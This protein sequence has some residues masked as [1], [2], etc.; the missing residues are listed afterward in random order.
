MGCDPLLD[1]VTLEELADHPVTEVGFDEEG[2]GLVA[3]SEA[4]DICEGAVG[5]TI[6]EG[7]HIP[8]EDVA[9]GLGEDT[10]D[11]FVEA[12]TGGIDGDDRF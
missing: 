2:A 5:V 10:G 11:G 3:L 7:S 8:Q 4:N 1:H 9:I 6:P 12:P